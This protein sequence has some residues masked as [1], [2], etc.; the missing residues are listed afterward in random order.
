MKE[1]LQNYLKVMTGDK[2]TFS[3]WE[4]RQALPLYLIEKYRYYSGMLMGVNCL[5]LEFL[6]DAPR[7][8]ILQKDAN[9]FVSQTD[10]PVVFLFKTI[11]PS[12]RKNLISHRIPFIV[13][14]GQMYLPFLGTDLSNRTKTQKEAKIIFSPITQLVYLNWLYYPNW[15]INATDLASHLGVSNMHAGRTLNDLDSLGLITY[16]VG[17]ATGRSKIYHRIPDPDFY[18]QGKD[19]LKSPVRKT[20]YMLDPGLPYKYAGLDALSRVSMLNPPNRSIRAISRKESKLLESKFITDIDRMYDDHVAEIQ[21][22]QYD[23]GL[24]TE[25]DQVD[26]VSLQLSL[27]SMMDERIEQALRDNMKGESWFVD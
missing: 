16:S 12:K 14:N 24:L 10:R 17:G 2:V 27:E 23:P 25:T 6:K 15:T 4:G 21:V 9:L 5:F 22:W 20:V 11:S 8:E 26:I 7:I 13:E 19:Y 1:I 18:R 3:S